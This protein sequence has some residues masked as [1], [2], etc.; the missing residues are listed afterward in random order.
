MDMKLTWCRV[1]G[2]DMMIPIMVT[3]TENTAVHVEWSD[4]VLRTLAPVKV[5]KPISMML[6]ARSIKPEN[7]YAALLLPK[8]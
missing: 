7:T 3:I 8:M 4:S 2:I 5:W 6:F 1:R